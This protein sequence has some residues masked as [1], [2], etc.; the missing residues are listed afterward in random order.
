M[1]SQV[2]CDNPRLMKRLV[3]AFTFMSLASLKRC[4]SSGCNAKSFAS[5][6][7]LKMIVL[8]II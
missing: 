6:P 5:R 3:H 7:A 1:S 2:V 8:V 4:L